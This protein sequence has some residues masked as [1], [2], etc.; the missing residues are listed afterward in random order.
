MET[1]CLPP[2]RLGTPA[3]RSRSSHVGNRRR[4]RHPPARSRIRIRCHQLNQ[5]LLHRPRSHL[6]PPKRRPRQPPPLCLGDSQ[7][8]EAPPGCASGRDSERRR[9]ATPFHLPQFFSTRSRHLRRRQSHRYPHQ[10]HSR[11]RPRFRSLHDQARSRCSWKFGIGRRSN[12]DHP[13]TCLNLLSQ[14]KSSLHSPLPFFS[15]LPRA[16]R[17]PT[18]PPQRKPPT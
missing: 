13:S 16:R 1:C 8:S 14:Q 17:K 9:V 6:P 5:R 4:T 7:P 18:P 11:R 3:Y 2:T 15:L 12:L 10:P